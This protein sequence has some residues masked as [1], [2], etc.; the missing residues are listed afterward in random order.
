MSFS[1][2]V[3]QELCGNLPHARHCRIAE[4][5]A[6]VTYAGHMDVDGCL[7]MGVE[8]SFASGRFEKLSE[9]VFGFKTSGLSKEM[10]RQILETIKA[11]ASLVADSVVYRQTCC[12]RAYLRGAFIACGTLNNP[13]KDYHLEF[14]TDGE[15]LQTIID[16][17][18]AFEIEAKSVERKKYNVVYVKDGDRIVDILNIMEAHIAMMD[19]ENAR[20]LKDVRNG[21]NRRVNCETANIRKTVTAA[22]RQVEDI[23]YIQNTIG[24]KALGREL[25]NTAVLRLQYPDCSLSELVSL[26]DGRVGRSGVN[27]RLSKLSDIA[28][29]LRAG[30][31]DGFRFKE[32]EKDDSQTNGN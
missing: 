16:I 2:D 15:R 19:F 25:E 24:L 5:A 7:N 23:E 1:S 26:H 14:V 29:R 13:E 20:I 28:E 30:S 18:A 6:I 32:E 22:K 11:D 12:K 21:V 31:V 8:N 27:H 10:T 3:K 9:K 4:L 17:L